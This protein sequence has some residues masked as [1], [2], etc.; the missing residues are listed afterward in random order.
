MPYAAREAL[1]DRVR[2]HLPDHTQDIFV[3]TFN[4][5][6]EECGSEATAFRVA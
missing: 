3:S 4:N 6:L 5:A 2:L 1:P